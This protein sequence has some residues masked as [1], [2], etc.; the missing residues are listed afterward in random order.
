[1][2]VPPKYIVDGLWLNKW[3]NEQKHIMQGRR[4]GKKLTDEQIRKLASISFTAGTKEEKWLQKYGELKKYY[5]LHG[6]IKLPINYTDSTGQNL[7]TWL[8]NQKISAKSGKM[9]EKRRKLLQD[10]G[11]GSL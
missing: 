4:E 1:M 10:L 8:T 2:N 6:N 5:D 7:Y 9:D 11:A 3:L